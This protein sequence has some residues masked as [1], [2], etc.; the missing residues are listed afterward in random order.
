MRRRH[1]KMFSFLFVFIAAMSFFLNYNHYE[2]MVSWA[3]QQIV[4]QFSE[5]FRKL[6]KHSRR[7][8]SCKAC[9]SELGLSLWFDERFNQ[10]MQPLLTTQNALISQDSYRWWLKLQ[11][12]KNPKNINETIKELFETISGDGN[13]LQERSSSMCRRCA[14]VGNSGNLRQSHYGQDID[15]HD[16]VLRMNRAPTVGFELDVGSKTT[17]H[18]I[19]PESFKELPE[20]VSMIVIPFKTLDLRWIV[21]ALTTGTINHTY[22]PVPRKIKVKKEKILVYHPDF[23]KY[24]FDHWLQRHGRYPSTG[25]LSVI[26]ALHVCDEVNLY[27]FGANSKGHW[28]HYW[29]NNPSA[30]AFRQTGVHDGDFESNITSTLAAVNKIR[31]FK[32]R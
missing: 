15:S 13:Q 10:T 20:N 11:G 32:G 4:M 28:H 26:F 14:V 5:Q 6:M 2:A 7:P 9:V 16:F 3:P 30:G 22:V 25:I 8:C 17:H 12:E 27:G 24:V 18:F 21:S 29:E 1:L 19:Y 31:L 23:L